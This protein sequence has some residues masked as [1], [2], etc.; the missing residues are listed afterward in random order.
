[1]FLRAS[2][3]GIRV[4]WSK[5][6]TLLAFDVLNCVIESGFIHAKPFQ[7]ITP[8]GEITSW[9]NSRTYNLYTPLFLFDIL[10]WDLLRARYVYRKTHYYSRQH[11]NRA[12]SRT[13]TA[14]CHIAVLTHKE[15]MLNPVNRFSSRSLF[16]AISYQHESWQDKFSKWMVFVE[17]VIHLTS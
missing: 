16:R 4:V 12:L 15:V 3:R 10:S 9:D 14:V 11:S 8:H 13:Y 1:M 5:Y 7:N 17:K 6:R 2:I